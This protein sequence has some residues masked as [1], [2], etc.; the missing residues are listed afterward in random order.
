[1][2]QVEE[3]APDV[4]SVG[5]KHWN[6][7][8]FDN[9]F[10][11]PY[12]T[13]YNAYLVK[14]KQKTALIDTTLAGFE[15]ELLDNIRQVE[16]PA[17]IDYVVMNHAEGD[18]AGGIPKLLEV[19][20][21]STLVTSIKGK[22]F[23]EAF[24]LVDPSRIRT[25]K[26]MDQI[27]LSGKILTFVDAPWLHWPETMFT[28]LEPDRILFPCDFFGAHFA[29]SKLYADEV[30]E[31]PLESKRYYTIIMAPYGQAAAAK[32][33]VE[34]VG[35]LNVKMIAPSHGPIH[36]YPEQI[37]E[38][39]RRW[40]NRQTVPKV[41]AAYGTMYGN[42]EALTKEVVKGIVSEGVEASV[43]DLSIS[44]SSY[45]VG[46]ALDAAGIVVGTP[47]MDGVP[48]P[49]VTMFVELVKL[50]RMRNKIS[51]IVGDFGWSGGAVTQVRKQLES[52]DFQIVGTV[53]VR[54]K[55]KSDELSKARELG[56]AIA[57]RII[58]GEIPK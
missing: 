40:A 31:L 18:H 38:S 7:R 42:T 39:Y 23:A 32:N 53:E 17:K 22:E 26:D 28:Y 36:R 14:G 58:Q 12:G 50:T 25:V 4:F 37:I 57:K 11:L 5:V 3:L 20:H 30:G 55:P 8:V 41:V 49:P 29:S 1:M 21:G 19:A 47:T 13:S 43:Y 44:D 45:V 48:F 54:G 24:Y 27:D 52:I 16:D 51:G 9:V 33:A 46:D 2:G 6:R 10:I 34:K 56:K 15:S 35:D